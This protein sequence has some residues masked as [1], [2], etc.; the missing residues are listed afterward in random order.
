MNDDL[1][2]MDLPM[3]LPLF[4]QVCGL[5][6]ALV[7]SL[8]AFALMGVAYYLAFHIKDDRLLAAFFP[9]T[10]LPFVAALL[11]TITG[12]LSSISMQVE[13][14]DMNL[15]SGFM[16]QMS[17]VPLLVGL[18]AGIP[19]AAIAAWG[20]WLIAWEASG[21][22]LADIIPKP[23]M[24]PVEESSRGEDWDQQETDDYLNTI[25]PK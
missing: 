6:L 24:D 2:L 23:D 3:N 17:V 7:V 16:L 14:S 11:S 8:L 5:S 12:T 19:A 25:R 4:L 22:T 20:R 9:F 18:F 21:V 10:G 13:N 1:R 15:D